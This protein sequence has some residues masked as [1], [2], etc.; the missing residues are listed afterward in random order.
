[1]EPLTE[2]GR[3]LIKTVL[4]SLLFAANGPIGLRAMLGPVREIHP[5]MN[6]RT[7]R[8]LIE[9]APGRRLAEAAAGTRGG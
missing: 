8:A 5:S 2:A 4:E 7:L 6:S 9:E 1:M 3:L